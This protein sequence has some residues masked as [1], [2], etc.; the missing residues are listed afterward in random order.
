M[1]WNNFCEKQDM[2]SDDDVLAFLKDQGL[3]VNVT[4]TEFKVKGGFTID[5]G[6]AQGL[7]PRGV[8]LCF[9]LIQQKIEA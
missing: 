2:A 3:E 5:G 9:Y 1:R 4:E 6:K 8:E 7:L